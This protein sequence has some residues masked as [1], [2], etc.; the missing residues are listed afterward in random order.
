MDF[1]LENLKNSQN[2]LNRLKNI[3]KELK[4][5]KKE[6]E[7]F[8]EKF[9]KSIN[10]DLNLPEALQI[11]WKLL[12]E[13]KA[14]GKLRTIKKMDLI[15]GLDLLKKEKVEIPEEIEKLTNEREKARREKNWER[16]DE[17]RKLVK[18][19]GFIIEDSDKGPILRKI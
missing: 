17:L 3:I 5:D 11:L 12:R 10:N 8:L 7:K 18:E 16:A 4:D 9:H 14:E 6:N 2:S 15:F 19:K 1:S 13:E